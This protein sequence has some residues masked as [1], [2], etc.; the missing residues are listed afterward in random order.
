M[1]RAKEIKIATHLDIACVIGT[2]PASFTAHR[3]KSLIWRV[4]KGRGQNLGY[5]LFGLDLVRDIALPI[6]VQLDR[7]R[8]S[9]PAYLFIDTAS[10]VPCTR[11]M[12]RP[13]GNQSDVYYT[14]KNRQLC[15]G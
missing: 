12:A 15:A 2:W 1:N 8:D 4:I 9:L 3:V 11:E 10:Q 5:D 13:T 14:T 6:R 7:H